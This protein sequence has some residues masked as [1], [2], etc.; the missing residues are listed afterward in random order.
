MKYYKLGEWGTEKKHKI[1]GK[2]KDWGS[3]N[4]IFGFKGTGSEGT[5]KVVARGKIIESGTRKTGK[6]GN[7]MHIIGF[8]EKGDLESKFTH[9]YSPK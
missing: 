2:F 1:I 8:L 7:K 5:I 9:N 3:K 4:A 6:N